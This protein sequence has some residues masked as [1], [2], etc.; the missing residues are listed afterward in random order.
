MLVR[1]GMNAEYHTSDEIVGPIKQR[2]GI[3]EAGGEP[4][5]ELGYANEKLGAGVQ[6]LDK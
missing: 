5:G 3:I 4:M 2:R 6:I 1:F